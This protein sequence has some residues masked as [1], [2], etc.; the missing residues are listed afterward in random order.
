MAASYL[1]DLLPHIAEGALVLT[2]NKRLF[3]FLRS[4]FDQWMLERGETVWTSPQ[5]FS[6]EGW[7]DQVVTGLGEQWRV[8]SP[9]QAQCMWEQLVEASSRSLDLELLQVSRTAEKVA[10]A[11]R[12]LNEYELELDEA[13]LTEDQQAFNLWRQQYREL[14]AEHDWLDR[15]ELA[16]LVREA[17]A[18]G[19]VAYPQRLFM[20]GFDQLPPGLVKLCAHF[21]D[22]GLDCRE[23]SLVAERD[24][25]VRHYSA[26]DSEDE[27]DKAAL[28]TRHLLEQ[29]ACSIGVVVPDLTT[30][31]TRIERSFLRQIDPQAMTRLEQ[32]DTVFGLSLGGPLAEEGVIHAALQLLGLGRKLSLN[33]VSFLLRTPYLGGGSREAD[34]RHLFERRLRSWRQSGFSLAA[35]KNTM[36]KNSDS[37]GIAEILAHLESFGQQGKL[38]PGEWAVCFGDD[39]KALGWPGDRVLSSREYQALKVFQD[40]VLSGL[41]ALD[42]V[43][44]AVTR[45]RALALLQ[46]LARNLEFQI[47]APPSPVQV[48][49]LLESSG[50]EFEHLW[51]MGMGETT[52]PAAP[53]PNPFIPYHLQR[54]HAMPHA[55]AERELQF[56]EQVIA[57]LRTAAA[58]VVFSYPRRSGESPQRPSPLLPAASCDAAPQFSAPQDLL[59]LSRAQAPELESL[60]DG[61]GPAL[62]EELV[63]G[64]TT[65]L[66]DQA[67]CPFRAF[68]HHRLKCTQ[69]DSPE[70]GISAVNRGD[71]VH[72][73]LEKIWR[74]LG[75]RSALEALS[76]EQRRTLIEQMVSA[77]IAEYFAEGSVLAGSLLQ[78][79]QERL[80]TLVGEWLKCEEQRD[81]F[82]VLESENE[83]VESLGPLK[84]RMKVDRIDQLADG[85]RVVIDYKTGSGIDARDFLSEPLIEPQLPIYAVAD[86]ENP[87]DGVAFARVR[88]GECAFVGFMRNEAALDKVS[89]YAAYAHKHDLANPDWD[90][91]LAFWKEQ[92]AA[93]AADFV[94]GRAVVDPFDPKRSCSYCDLAGLC[95]IQEYYGELEES[96]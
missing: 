75:R 66:K 58:Q 91:L 56:G 48:V 90:Q 21:S 40:K 63:E 24:V 27:I 65:L 5:I 10:Q 9:H 37:G 96:E 33:E 87:A 71:L 4:R 22:Q 72:L 46:N 16:A 86:G 62:V 47:E 68:I 11:H 25:V 80:I 89:D 12:L 74:Q 44:P 59:S 76:S 32:D 26:A 67:H 49:G 54:D 14:C 42:A 31:R 64:G 69:L 17:F 36:E 50:L 60:D 85:Q 95:R 94:A 7:I 79:E 30:C 70:A 41:A 61:Q 52:L 73:V 2:A 8:L 39:L 78:I 53:Q 3:R 43:L 93:L 45:G 57:R 29:G 38:H 84:I 82:V 1:T 92:I 88:Q 18:G 77:A 83:H 19:Q 34:Q 13:S 20:V 15:S 55:T 81:D 28:W 35:L 6:Y 23:L 51:V